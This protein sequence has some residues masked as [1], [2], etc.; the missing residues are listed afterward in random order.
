M[1][2]PVKQVTP[3]LETLYMNSSGEVAVFDSTGR[4]IYRA[5]TLS[6][7][8]PISGYA[9]SASTKAE[10]ITF[11]GT[12]YVLQ[13]AVSDKNGWTYVSAIRK[14]DT[15]SGLANR[16]LTFIILLLLLLFVAIV[17]MLVCIVVQYM[18]IS[19][20]AESVTRKSGK[21]EVI[22]ERVLL[23]DAIATLKDDS[24]QKQRFETAYYEAEAA[25]KAK[26]AFLSNMSHDIRTPMNAIIGMTAIAQRHA[27]DPE[28]VRDCLQKVELSSQY[29][30]DII[31]NVLD[32]S[33]IESGRVVLSEEAVDLS[34]L[35]DGL[36]AIIGPGAEAKS[37]QLIVDV[38]QLDRRLVLG[39]S[40]RLTQVFVKFTPEGGRIEMHVRQSPSDDPEYGSYV[41]TFSDNGIG[42]PPEFVGQVF[43]TFSRSSATSLS[44]IEGTGL[45]MAIAK[46]L[47]ELMGGAIVCESELNKGTTFTVTLRMKLASGISAA[48]PSEEDNSPAE[49]IDL[50]GKRV[51][52]VEDNSINRV[53][54]G[55]IIGET[56]AEVVE[57]VN[58]KEAV[59]LFSGSPE[60]FFDIILMDIQMPVMNGYEA[61][62]AIRSLSRAD[63]AA[64]PIFAMTANT[65]DEDVRQVKDSG[66]NGHLGKPYKPAELYRILRNALLK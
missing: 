41:F 5:G 24:E 52:L 3:L 39:D 18:P 4:E 19:D 60:G 7:N 16:Q 6:D 30:L 49:I 38:G 34:V 11:E 35:A 37:Q 15:L 46:N 8:L 59:E 21:G 47:V 12:D 61:T 9:S 2:I 36:R 31:N 43:D 45:G 1:L 50:T 13:K 63:A 25:S 44:R 17:A 62:A 32:M 29:L 48:A 57:A 42:M 65:F 51:L 26:S 28:Y 53:I 14:S 23:S 58:G 33:R 66:M 56:Q 40:V 22:D 54:A 10:S 20:L 55:K 27:D 64:V